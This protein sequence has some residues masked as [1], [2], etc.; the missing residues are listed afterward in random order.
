MFSK[1]FIDVA[2][3]LNYINPFS[4]NFILK[5]V[6]NFLSDILSYINPFSQ[7]FFVYKLIELLGNMLKWLFVPDDNFFSSHFGEIKETLQNKLG[8][9]GYI[10]IFSSLEDIS[11]NGATTVNLKGYKIGNLNIDVNKF[12]NFNSI[13]KYKD[14]WYS[15]VRAFM[16]IGLLIY[17]INQVYKLIRGTNLADSQKTISHIGGKKE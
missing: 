8:Y 9:Q 1:L 5:N 16:F 3:I 17:N 10:D 2:N 12:I 6:I 14:T 4:E 13:L 15:W 11:E 7:N